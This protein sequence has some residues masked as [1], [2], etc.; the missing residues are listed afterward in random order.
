MSRAGT[1]AGTMSGTTAAGASVNRALHAGFVLTMAVY[2]AAFASTYASL[3][4]TWGRTGTFEYAYLIFPVCAVLVWG[5]RAWLARVAAEPRPRALVLALGLGGLWLIGAAARINLFQ[6]VAVVA[7]WPV[8]IYVFY[9]RAVARVLAF[10]MGYVLFAIPFGNFMVEPLQTV[11]AHLSVFALGFTD[12]PVFMSGHMIDTP[13]S[14]WHVAEACSGIKFFVATTAFGVL[15]AYLFYQSLHRRLIFIAASMIVPIIANGLRVFFTIL[16][17]EYFGLEYATGTD[18]AIFGWQFFGTVLV[19]LFLAGWPW[20]EPPPRPPAAAAAD[21]PV[22][23]RRAIVVTALAM[24]VI[25]VPAVWFGVASAMAHA[26][27]RTAPTLPQTLAGKK[28]DDTGPWDGPG[29]PLASERPHV[30]RVYGASHG[31]IR[32]DYVRLAPD[33]AADRV[34][35]DQRWQVLRQGSAALKG[36]AAPTFRRLELQRRNA[37]QRWEIWSVARIGDRWL[38]PGPMLRAWQ[39]LYML[40]GQSGDVAVLRLAQASA[41]AAD[42]DAALVDM[43]RAAVEAVERERS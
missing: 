18:H 9:G 23:G 34:H 10:P 38:N 35:D 41:A 6:H 15:Y 40:S 11:T 12:V 19:L 22:A 26:A 31:A 8:L 4:A 39:A 28:A 27:D 17:G 32:V 37:S 30:S 43:A 25:I 1:T 36:D 29:M 24:V 42:D 7:M 5:R 20:H 3:V 13:V 21:R 14:A 16:I 33:D 2:V